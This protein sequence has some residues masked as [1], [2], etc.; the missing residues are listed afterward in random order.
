MAQVLVFASG[1]R[2]DRCHHGHPWTPGR[3]RVSWFTCD[4]PTAQRYH[5]GHHVIACAEP[6]C[7][8]HWT[9]PPHDPH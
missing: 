7:S 2:P 3:F 4:C 1:K 9:D 5:F 6:G 8:S